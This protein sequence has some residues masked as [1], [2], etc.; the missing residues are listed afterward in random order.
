VSRLGRRFALG[1]DDIAALH[2]PG[3]AVHKA[4]AN[5]RM[6]LKLRSQ[7][8]Q[9]SVTLS[10]MNRRRGPLNGGQFSSLR[11]SG[12]GHPKSEGQA[13]RP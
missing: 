2:V 10:G 8:F 13:A 3:Q 7:G 1:R 11:L 5:D 6:L 9:K 4:R 12:T